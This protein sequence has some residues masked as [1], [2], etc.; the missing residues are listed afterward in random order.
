MTCIHCKE[1]IAPAQG[2]YVHVVTSEALSL[3]GGVHYAKPS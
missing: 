2:I 1:A 3:K